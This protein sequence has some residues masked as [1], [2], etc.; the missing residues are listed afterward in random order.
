MELLLALAIFA[1][2]IIRIVIEDRP[3]NKMNSNNQYKCP[4]T[5]DSWENRVHMTATQEQKF[6]EEMMSPSKYAKMRDNALKT[7]RSF[8]GLDWACFEPAHP[9]QYGDAEVRKVVRYIEFVKRG[10]LPKEAIFGTPPPLSEA[11]DLYVPRSAYIDFGRW[12][13]ETLRDSGIYDARLYCLKDEGGYVGMRWEPYVIGRSSPM[14]RVTD[15]ELENRMT[16]GYPDDVAEE[17]NSFRVKCNRAIDETQ[18]AIERL[19]KEIEEE[20]SAGI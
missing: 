8:R 16:G 11:V 7:I 2:W 12:I 15:P 14:L 1:Y 10:Y 6:R 9:K 3:K 19:D 17:L 4:Y 5:R 13:E 18:K 20:K